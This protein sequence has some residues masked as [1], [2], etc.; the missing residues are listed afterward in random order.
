MRFLVYR[1]EVFDTCTKEKNNPGTPSS[2]QIKHSV[3]WQSMKEDLHKIKKL[4]TLSTLWEEKAPERYTESLTGVKCVLKFGGGVL[5]V[6][7]FF[8]DCII[9]V[10]S[11]EN[12]IPG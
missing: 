8:T 7:S 1:D 3:I 10:E 6:K 11:D 5:N 4:M 9:C 12:C 2:W